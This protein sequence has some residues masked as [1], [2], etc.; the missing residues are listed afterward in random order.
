MRS[1]ARA[2][3]SGAI[4]AVFLTRAI[5]ASDR[6]LIM[7]KPQTARSVSACRESREEAWVRTRDPGI[8]TVIKNARV[9]LVFLP[10]ENEAASLVSHARCR[11]SDWKRAGEVLREQAGVDRRLPVLLVLRAQAGQQ[12]VEKCALDFN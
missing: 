1:R 3:G 11:E 2:Q 4:P 7:T 8:S 6:L 12:A 5:S 9:L 10:P